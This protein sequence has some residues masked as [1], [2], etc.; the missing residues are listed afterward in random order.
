MPTGVYVRKTKPILDRFWDKV[1]K[2]DTCWEWTAPLNASGYGVLAFRKPKGWGYVFA[3]R[4]AFEALVS[5]IPPNMCV[6]HKCDNR[7]CVNPDHLFL[8]TQAENTADRDNKGRHVALKGENHGC[9]YL[10]E[11]TVR[12]IIQVYA[13]GNYTQKELGLKFGTTTWNIHRIVKRKT[14]K[15]LKVA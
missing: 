5:E 3:H 4:F 2:T 14:W 9:A 13:S 7:K 1:N 15:H 11:D 12:E 10:N 6:C 8:G